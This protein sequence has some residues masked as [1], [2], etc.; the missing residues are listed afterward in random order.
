MAQV[1][2]HCVKVL[3]QITDIPNK[4]SLS[5]NIFPYR[6]VFF[7]SLNRGCP[8]PDFRNTEEAHCRDGGSGW[9]ISSVNAD[10][11]SL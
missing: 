1:V 7:F 3:D 6:I 5:S 9:Y 4:I 8:D 10:P 11:C 2:L